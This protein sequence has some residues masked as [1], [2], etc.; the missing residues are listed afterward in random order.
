MGAGE[1]NAE[2]TYMAR[3]IYTSKD[4]L[5]ATAKA[6]AD[7]FDYDES[8]IRRRASLTRRGRGCS[9]RA[10]PRTSCPCA[11]SFCATTRGTR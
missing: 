11:G 2:I 5:D 4:E 9:A 7:N 1:T 3:T 8:F 10:G 6:L